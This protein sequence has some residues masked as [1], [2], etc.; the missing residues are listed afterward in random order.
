MIAYRPNMARSMTKP[1]LWA[2]LMTSRVLIGVSSI[3][4]ARIIQV[5][6]TIWNSNQ[7]SLQ[8]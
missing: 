8:L 7:I 2:T 4:P 3:L 5:M 1:H 6:A